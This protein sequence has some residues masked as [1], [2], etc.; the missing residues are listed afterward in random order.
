[1]FNE[2]TFDAAADK[3]SVGVRK[4]LGGVIGTRGFAQSFESKVDNYAQTGGLLDSRISSAGAALTRIGSQLDEFDRRMDT[5]QSYY[6]AQFQALE[7]AM[8]KSQSLASQLAAR[9]GT[10]T[11]A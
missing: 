10:T 3:D 7:K 4:L 9:L 5:R 6:Q 8:A 11:T 1:V 2:A